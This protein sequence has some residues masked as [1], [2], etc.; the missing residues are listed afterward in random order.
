MIIEHPSNFDDLAQ[1]TTKHVV[2][3]TLSVSL[4]GKLGTHVIDNEL[5][6]VPKVV[7]EIHYQNAE[8][9]NVSVTLF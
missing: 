8:H 2:N 4:N 9:I 7:P 1:L 6:V 3:V 5:Q